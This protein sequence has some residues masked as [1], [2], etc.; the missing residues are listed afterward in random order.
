MASHDNVPNITHSGAWMASEDLRCF[1]HCLKGTPN[2][3][4]DA[5][6]ILTTLLKP[7]FSY[8]RG[9]ALSSVVFVDD[10][11]LQGHTHA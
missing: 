7:P 5:M 8:L 3:Y 10:T 9:K 4:A 2:G 11:Y 6:R 1:L